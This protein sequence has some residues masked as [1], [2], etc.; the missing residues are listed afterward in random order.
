[1]HF[2]LFQGWVRQVYATQ[3]EELDCDGFFEVIS[4][5]VDMEVAGEK[6]NPHVPQVEHHLGQCP[7]CQDLYLTLRDAALLEDQQITLLESQQIEMSESRQI[8]MFE[9]LERLEAEMSESH[10]VTPVES[11]HTWQATPKSTAF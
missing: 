4:E 10:Q 9:L 3:D 2:N 6:T 11:Q 8:E 1:M 7:H 5:Y